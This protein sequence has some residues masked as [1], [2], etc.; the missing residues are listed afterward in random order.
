MRKIY[1]MTKPI[2]GE[3]INSAHPLSKGIV[4]CWLFNEG[5]GD[6]VYDSSGNKNTGTLVSMA[7]PSS[8]ISG[9][10]PG[11]FGKTLSFDGSND[12]VTVVPTPDGSSLNVTGKISFGGW[13]FPRV[14]NVYQNV[15]G[16]M[17]GTSRQYAFYL[18]GAGVSTIYCAL[19]INGSNYQGDVTLSFPWAVNKWNHVFVVYDGSSRK[20]YLNGVQAY[21]NN[22]AGAITHPANANLYLG[23]DYDGAYPLN[24]QMDLPIIYNRALSAQEILQLYK[25]PFCMFDR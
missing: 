14:S 3:K 19:F 23:K 5:G 1:G 17:A 11:R 21:S 7:I 9:W 10:N 25:G 15:I 22:V 2:K 8:S 20:I 16:F 4:G 24:G 18:S 6:K 12:T 13:V